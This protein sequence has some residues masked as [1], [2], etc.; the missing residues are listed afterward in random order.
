MSNTEVKITLGAKATQTQE[1]I[2]AAN[3]ILSPE[4]YGG[5][6]VALKGKEVVAYGDT[7]TEVR[8]K[9]G[10]GFNSDVLLRRG[11]KAILSS[12]DKVTKQ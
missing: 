4:E 12:I 2:D 6:W 3:V 7:V 11:P 9:L 8:D 10:E 1:H 5:K